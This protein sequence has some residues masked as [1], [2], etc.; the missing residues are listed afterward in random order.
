MSIRRTKIVATVGPACQNV[1]TLAAMIQAGV[2]VFRLNMAHG[3]IPTHTLMVER[4]RQ[5]AEQARRPIGLLA[6]LAGPKLRL[7]KLTGEG[8]QCEPGDTLFLRRG[9]EASRPN[10]L[11]SEY[12]SLLDEIG[13]GDRIIIGDGTIALEVTEA[14]SEEAQ[15][16][17]LD[18]G[19]IRSRQGLALP[20]T[21]LSIKTLRPV[22]YEHAQWAAEL[23]LDYVSLSFVRSPADIEEL[24]SHLEGCQATAGIIAKIEKR[25]SL[26]CLDEIIKAADGIMV[27]RGDLGLEIDIASTAVV[28]KEIIARCQAHQKPVIVATQMLESMHHSKRPTRAEVSDVSNAI[29]DGADACMLS[30]E[31]AVGK[32]P[33]DTVKMMSNIQQEAEP[34]SPG[35]DLATRGS[36]FEEMELTESVL[37][38]AAHVARSIHS[39]IVAIATK[40]GSPAIIKS[41]LRDRTPTLCITDS[42]SIHGQACLWWGVTPWYVESLDREGELFQAIHDWNGWTHLLDKNDQIVI[43]S[44]RLVYPAGHD[45]ILVYEL[46]DRPPSAS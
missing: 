27:A 16:R 39:K 35:M 37:Q 1:D 34:L 8:I 13:E 15:L 29:L 31:T 46:S 30:G 22:D 28:Q 20:H 2:N 3:D 17:V 14:K 40:T 12:E 42:R 9:R 6:D 19:A 32:Y 43:V 26:D 4:I 25:E 7:G 21:R 11:V 44:D 36:N 5:A 23:N 24:R 18:G 41:K 10:E 45:S 38:G 33:V